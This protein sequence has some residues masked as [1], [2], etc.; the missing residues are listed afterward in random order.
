MFWGL[1]TPNCCNFSPDATVYQQC[2][3][4]AVGVFPACLLNSARHADK[5]WWK[6]DTGDS[7]AWRGFIAWNTGQNCQ[8]PALQCRPSSQPCRGVC[9]PRQLCSTSTTHYRDC[10]RALGCLAKLEHQVGEVWQ[11]CSQ[12]VG[13]RRTIMNSRISGSVNSKTPTTL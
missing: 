3:C 5:L 13:W 7:A 4:A 9:P 12:P 6:L 8:F 11:S 1:L 2:R 10:H